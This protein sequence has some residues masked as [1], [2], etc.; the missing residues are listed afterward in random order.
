MRAE[1]VRPARLRNYE[2]ELTVEDVKCTILEAARAT[3]A[4]SGFFTPVTI[5]QQTFVDAAVGYNNPVNE[6]FDEVQQIWGRSNRGMERFISIGT[7]IPSLSA[8]GS[9]LVKLGMTLVKIA[10]DTQ[11]VA[12]EFERDSV[13]P[14]GLTG[15]YYRFNARGM[16]G[17]GLEDAK[18]LGTVAAATNNYL[19]E[20]ETQKKINAFAAVSSGT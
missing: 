7:G 8:F 15:L 14:N 17:V 19:G 1:V 6:V 18:S 2:T 11:K 10:T 12:D 13:R 4:A 5:E 3:S 20:Y 9:T 16:E